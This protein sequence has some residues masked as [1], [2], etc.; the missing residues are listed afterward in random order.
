MIGMYF[1]VGRQCN[2]D[3]HYQGSGSMPLT[4]CVLAGFLSSRSEMHMIL[5][6]QQHCRASLEL[7]HKWNS[8]ELYMN[9]K[10]LC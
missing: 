8:C 2:L 4:G 1:A 6:W 9:L 3:M 7:A 5:K 10:C